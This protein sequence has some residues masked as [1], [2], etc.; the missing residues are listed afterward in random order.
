M[1]HKLQAVLATEP[2]N[3][4]SLLYSQAE[5]WIACF[6]PEEHYVANWTSA[7]KDWSERGRQESAAA[8]RPPRTAPPQRKTGLRFLRAANIASRGA[9]TAKHGDYPRTDVARNTTRTTTVSPQLCTSVKYTGKQRAGDAS[10]TTNRWRSAVES[11]T[12]NGT[13]VFLSYQ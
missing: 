10:G 6:Y 8:N 2:A 11:I 5:A 9:K 1:L 12:K 4:S 13:R 7:A 3:E